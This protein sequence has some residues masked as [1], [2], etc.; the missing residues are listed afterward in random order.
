MG[1]LDGFDI[2]SLLGLGGISGIK[3]LF[4]ASALVGGILFVLY[5]FLLMIGGIATD[6][7]DGLFG[8]EVD[9]GADASFKALTFQGI[10]AFMMF[11]GLAGLY[12]MESNGGASL[13]V[14]AG[15]L[16]GGVSMYFTGKLFELFVTL[17]QDGTT[18][19]SEAIGSKGQT[20]L[21]ISEGGLGQVTVEVNGIQRTYNARSEDGAQIGTGDFIE[22]VDTI[23]EVLVVKRI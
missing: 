12:T 16:A 17:Q 3:L 23:G 10:M 15:A 22:V 14:V 19:L 9:V 18:E 7:F 11:F 8:I 20:Y 1:L 6:V 21:R 5:F 4:A 13:A 2:F